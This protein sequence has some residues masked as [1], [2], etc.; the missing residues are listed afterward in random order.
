[1]NRYFVSYIG[2]IIFYLTP[3][4][5]YKKNEQKNC[6]GQQNV[7]CCVGSAICHLMTLRNFFCINVLVYPLLCLRLLS[8][9]LYIL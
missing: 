6:V 9:L 5:I 4:E 1:M 7:H 8:K 3:K 2:E